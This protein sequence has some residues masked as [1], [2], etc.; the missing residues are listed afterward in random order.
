MSG[1]TDLCANAVAN[2][3]NLLVA[4][5]TNVLDSSHNGNIHLLRA[6]GVVSV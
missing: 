5:A 1:E 6:V 2:A 4:K 3:A